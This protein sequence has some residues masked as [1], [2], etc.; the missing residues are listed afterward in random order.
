[1]HLSLTTRSHGL[2]VSTTFPFLQLLVSVGA[3]R[4][5]ETV[6][7]GEE[8]EQRYAT[9][10]I[11]GKEFMQRCT[12]HPEFGANRHKERTVSDTTC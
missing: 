3:V 10:R 6:S 11:Q 5:Q 9:A 4:A 12:T 8:S 1:M 2:H 7:L